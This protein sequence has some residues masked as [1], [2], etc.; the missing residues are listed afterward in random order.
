MSLGYKELFS[1]LPPQRL[2]RP[3][4]HRETEVLVVLSARLSQGLGLGV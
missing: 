1:S 3:E 4:T 2:A